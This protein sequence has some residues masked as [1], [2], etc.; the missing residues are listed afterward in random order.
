VA[1]NEEYQKALAFRLTATL[2]E[3]AATECT[4]ALAI[5]AAIV[6][7]L[8]GDRRTAAILAHAVCTSLAQDD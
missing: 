3:K 2:T 5:Y 4:A 7:E 8:E 6:D 1:M